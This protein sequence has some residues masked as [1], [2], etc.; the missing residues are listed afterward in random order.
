MSDAF[1]FAL[2]RKWVE[3]YAEYFC[4][5]VALR[6]LVRRG[7]GRGLVRGPLTTRARALLETTDQLAAFGLRPALGLAGTEAVL[8]SQTVRYAAQIPWLSPPAGVPLADLAVDLGRMQ[9]AWARFET[10]VAELPD[11]LYDSC[12]AVAGGSAASSPLFDHR[13]APTAIV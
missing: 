10:A 7:A 3:E 11:D 9:D 8:W 6:E 1:P 13:V 4:L 5:T 2:A 12:S